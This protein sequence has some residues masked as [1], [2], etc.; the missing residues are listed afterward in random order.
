MANPRLTPDP[1]GMEAL[2]MPG[3]R[4]PCSA[5]T[6]RPCFSTSPGHSLGQM[7]TECMTECS[8]SHFSSVLLGRKRQQKERAWLRQEALPILVQTNNK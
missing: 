6:V 1:T 4:A 5:P 2:V 7:M 3:L 8:P